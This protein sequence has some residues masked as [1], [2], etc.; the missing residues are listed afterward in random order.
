MSLN[1]SF[2]SS[3]KGL[4]NTSSDCFHVLRVKQEHMRC[5]AHATRSV[6]AGTVVTILMGGRDGQ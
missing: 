5:P 3:A 2:S 1:L 6:T 4:G